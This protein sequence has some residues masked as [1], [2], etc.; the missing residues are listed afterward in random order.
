M[1]QNGI[2]RDKRVQRRDKMG[3]NGTK[4]DKMGQKRGQERVLK[5]THSAENAAY[6]RWR[7]GPPTWP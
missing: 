7:F 5:V 4:W 2:K 3:Q 1:G 6:L